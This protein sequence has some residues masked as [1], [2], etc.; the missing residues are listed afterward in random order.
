MSATTE[1]I[2]PLP[3]LEFAPGAVG[4]IKR[5]WSNAKPLEAPPRETWSVALRRAR[6]LGFLVLGT[7]LLILCWWVG[8]LAHRMA[9][10]KDFAAYS[11]ATYLISHGTLNPYSTPFLA[12][13]WKNSVE[14]VMWPLAVIQMVWPHPV[15]LK[16]LQV[17]AMVGAEGVALAWICDI[18]AVR[19][20]S[21]R[22][23]R[24]PVLLV[25]L[26][27]LLLVTNP[28]YVYMLS[29]DF[30]PGPFMILFLIA[31]ARDAHRGR[32]SAWIWGAL[33][34]GC[35][36]LGGTYLIAL[37]IGLALTGRFMVRRGLGLALLGLVWLGIVAAL[38]GNGSTVVYGSLIAG[39]KAQPVA[40]GA[41]LSNYTTIDVVKALVE[42]PGRAAGILWPNRVNM[43]AE[44]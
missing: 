32:W 27:V 24:A 41:A 34:V 23:S 37:G 12:T 44:V 3:R 26:G 1:P 22:S 33:L 2:R 35:S 36:A 8:L 40:A 11:Q 13:F 4:Q 38:H 7:Q 16:V 17:L 21:D 9:L 15:T 18:A 42:H 20:V 28:W 29:F 14:L 25:G 6:R 10:T 30:H 19:A 43:W 31:T 39:T 5:R